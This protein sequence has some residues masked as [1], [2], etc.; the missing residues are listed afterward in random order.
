MEANA[1]PV[2]YVNK[3]ISASLNR[4]FVLFVVREIGKSGFVNPKNE[5][6]MLN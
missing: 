2:Q 5:T 3:I 4:V 1:K 6:C